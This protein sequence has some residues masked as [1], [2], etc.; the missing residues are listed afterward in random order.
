MKKS[1]REE[2][3]SNRPIHRQYIF[4]HFRAIDPKFSWR[5]KKGIRKN[6]QIPFEK[7]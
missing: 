5:T 1:K 6:F 7:K 3:D 2:S 4:E